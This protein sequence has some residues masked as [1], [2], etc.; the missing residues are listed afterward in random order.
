M[1]SNQFTDEQYYEYLCNDNILI[2][3][4]Y[5]NVDI[6]L[7][8]LNFIFNTEKG[9]LKLEEIITQWTEF[10]NNNI[11]Y[12]EINCDNMDINDKFSNLKNIVKEMVNPY[13][14]FEVLA[15]L[16]LPNS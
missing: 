7:Y 12:D 14:L 2:D 13:K 3:D 1:A 11:N 4:K 9:N 6:D 5:S 10:I 16:K 15:G 8:C